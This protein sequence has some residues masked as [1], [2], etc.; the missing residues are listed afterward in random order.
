M[1]SEN[2]ENELSLLRPVTQ[3]W[4]V[5]SG[6]QDFISCAIVTVIFTVCKSRRLL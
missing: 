6:T 5:K 2:T 1:D 4:L 3:Q